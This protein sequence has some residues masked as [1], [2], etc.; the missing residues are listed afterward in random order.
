ML[1]PLEGVE[2]ALG[3]GSLF[4]VVRSILHRQAISWAF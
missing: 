4:C 1:N 2:E 3:V